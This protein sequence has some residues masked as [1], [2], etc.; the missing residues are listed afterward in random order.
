MAVET[1]SDHSP[2]HIPSHEEL[3]N[4]V[5]DPTHS[6]TAMLLA[7]L[8]KFMDIIGGRCASVNVV[9]RVV[10]GCFDHVQIHSREHHGY[11]VVYR[12]VLVHTW[13][14][15]IFTHIY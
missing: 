3:F 14:V 15:R 8:L 1:S 13:S 4:V 7:A 9:G 5:G 10:T 6:S 11:V 2:C 12:V